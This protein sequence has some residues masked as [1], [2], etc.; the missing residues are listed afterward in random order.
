MDDDPSYGGNAPAPAIK[1][2]TRARAIGAGKAV[3]G[4]KEGAR[5]KAAA[6]KS[7]TKRPPREKRVKPEDADGLFDS[8]FD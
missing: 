8:V 2:A 1:G 4:R 5:G 7:R 6:R 3:S